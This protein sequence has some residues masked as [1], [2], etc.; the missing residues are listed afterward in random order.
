MR[1]NQVAWHRSIRLR[2]VVVA[3]MVEALMLSLLLANSYRLVSNALEAQTSSR[4]EALTPLLNAS[5]AGRV[6]QRDYAEIEAI[7][8]QLLASDLTEIAYI[9]V[10]DANGRVMAR[11]GQI[12][13]DALP[14][15]DH[16]VQDAMS[17]QIFDTTIPLSIQ[18]SVIGRVNFGLSMLH[19]VTL[20]G[21]VLQQSLLIAAIEILLSPLLLATAGYI[22]TRHIITLLEATQR[23]TQGKYS[24]HIEVQQRD[25]IGLL[26]ENFNTMSEAIQ[27]RIEALEESDSRFRAIF[28]AVGDGI[29]IHDAASGALIDVNE[30]MCEMYQCSREQALANT[31][32]SCIADADHTTPMWVQQQLALVRK[33]HSHTFEVLSH[34]LDGTHRF[35]VEVNLRFAVLGH[36]ERII[37]LVRDISERKQAE[38]EQRLAATAFET[39]EAIVI[40]DTTGTILR[41]NQAFSRITGYST[42]EAI[43]NN[44]RMLKSGRHDKA[45]YQGFWQHLLAHGHWRGE[46]WNRRKNGEIYSEWLSVSAVR[47][48]QGVTSHYIGISSDQSVWVAQR[49]Q[50]KLLLNSTAEGIIGTD[51]QGVITFANPAVFEMLGGHHLPLIGT[52]LHHY[53]QPQ[54]SADAT[55]TSQLQRVL[56]GELIQDADGLLIS[57]Q[58]GQLP[59]EYWLRP[60]IDHDQTIGV[61]LTCVDITT[62]KQA[63][64]ELQQVLSSL[65]ERVKERTQQLTHKISELEQTRSELIQSEKMASLGRLVAGFAHEINTPIGIAVGGASLIEESSA[66]IKQLLEQEEVD[67]DEL[68]RLLNSIQEA[69]RLTLNSLR[70]AAKLVQ[71]FKRTAVDQSN[72]AAHSFDLCVAIEDTISSLHSEF[73]HRHIQV[74]NRCHMGQTIFSYPGSIEQILTNLLINS[75]RHGFAEDEPGGNIDIHTTLEGDEVVIDYRDSGCGMDQ[76]TREKVFEPFF[77][78]ARGRGGSGLGLFICYNLVTSELQGSIVCES[79]VGAGCRFIIRFPSSILLPA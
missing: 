48:P 60:I 22:I 25:E 52:K 12:D 10:Y 31:I 68:I 74:S 57:P 43:G 24:T 33:S 77:T 64:T 53:L 23:V 40:T 65:E 36:D 69:S 51:R 6:F 5:L 50:I 16:D 73:K 55:A 8:Q 3:L 19:M 1:D 45:F 37:A 26:T 47:D 34:T 58:G 11:Q 66:Q 17:D 70:R 29:F 78:T 14:R 59:V 30:R 44:P 39:D 9:I 21:S 76:A 38:Q 42:H 79:D 75:V 63:A 15:E 4:L 20:R 71:S 27:S 49:N 18:N 7:L 61:I 54:M 67:V 72:L 32:E 35:W 28:N 46:I 56:S 62:R 41:V 2:I 13:I